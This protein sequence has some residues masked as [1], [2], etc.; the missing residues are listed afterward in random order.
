ME[1]IQTFEGY[2][3]RLRSFTY[4]DDLQAFI[5][6]IKSGEIQ[7][8]NLTP[9]QQAEIDRLISDLLNALPKKPKPPKP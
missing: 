1:I 7:I 8:P 6:K 2:K 5:E 4:C 9:E 3:A